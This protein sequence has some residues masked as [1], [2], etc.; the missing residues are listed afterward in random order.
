MATLKEQ[1]IVLVDHDSGGNP[2]LQ[3]PITRAANVEDLTSTC[4]PLS[5]GN[6]TGNLTVQN[7]NVVRS[8]NGTIADSTGNVTISLPDT[9]MAYVTTTYSNG[10][11]RYRKWSD[12]FIEIWMYGDGRFTFPIAFT[13]ANYNVMALSPGEGTNGLDSDIYSKSTTKL[14]IGG[15]SSSYVTS[16]IYCSGY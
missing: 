4:L 10:T 11:T 2:I 7:K 16:Y 1:D 6:L 8:V 13:N 15:S 14:W 9:P 12:G 5:G 3:M